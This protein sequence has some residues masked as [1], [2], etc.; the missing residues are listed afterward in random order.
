VNLDHLWLGTHRLPGIEE[1][2]IGQETLFKDLE[3]VTGSGLLTSRFVVPVLV[4]PVGTVMLRAPKQFMSG[5]K[6]G[7]T[8]QSVLVFWK[9]EKPPA[10]KGIHEQEA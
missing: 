7:R 4:T 3:P 6:L 1:T 8:H 10:W 2:P 5:R 9:G